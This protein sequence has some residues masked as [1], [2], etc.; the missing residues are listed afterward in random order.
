MKYID[1][2]RQKAFLLI[3]TTPLLPVPL[4]ICVNIF[5]RGSSL[6][7]MFITENSAYVICHLRIP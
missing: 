6:L 1:S 7:V 4:N 2:W 5:F 3:Y